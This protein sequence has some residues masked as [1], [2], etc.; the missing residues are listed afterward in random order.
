MNPIEI[1]KEQMDFINNSVRQTFA[2][3]KEGDTED[4]YSHPVEGKKD[5]EPANH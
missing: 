2:A 3:E 1:I 4:S 5:Y